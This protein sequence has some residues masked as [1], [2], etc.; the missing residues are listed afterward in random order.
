MSPIPPP[1]SWFRLLATSNWRRTTSR[2]PPSTPKIDRS[3]S[4][5]HEPDVGTDASTQLPIAQLMRQ[6]IQ[7]RKLRSWSYRTIKVTEVLSNQINRAPR[8]LSPAPCFL[9]STRF[10]TVFYLTLT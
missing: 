3:N 6:V 8:D 2:A 1:S 9:I 5:R 4:R 10:D 7:P